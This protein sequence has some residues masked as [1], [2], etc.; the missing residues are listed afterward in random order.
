MKKITFTLDSRSIS[1]AIK[2]LEKYRDGLRNKCTE[3]R[4]RVAEKI[5]WS[6]QNGFNT[7]MVSD[8]FLRVEGKNRSTE[9]PI[10]G[11]NVKV[12]V[13]HGDDVSIVFTE[14]E[15]AIFIEFGA[16]VYHNGAAG[17]SPNPWG[18]EMGYV[19]GAYPG[20]H[21]VPSYGVRGSWGYKDG[22]GV[23]ITHGTPAAMPMYRGAEEAVRTIGELIREVFGND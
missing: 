21:G 1:Q 14:G 10:V 15:E 23:V 20:E 3:L 9:Q 11:S 4:K 7:A 18:I 5:Q 8:T 13:T 2:E 12:E 16:G 22:N 19:I 6:A 17:D